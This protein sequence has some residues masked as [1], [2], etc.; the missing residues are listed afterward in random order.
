MARASSYSSRIPV[1]R[2]R[3]FLVA[4]RRAFRK[5]QFW[6]GFVILVPLLVWYT[7]FSFGPILRA[8]W[9][10]VVEYSLLEPAKSPFVGLK[11]FQL[12]FRQS[13]FWES[14]QHTL[15]Y[16]AL[17]FLFMLPLALAISVCLTSVVRGRSF[18]QFAIFLPVVVSLVSISLM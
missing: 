13:L 11:N 4:T 10:T 9:M 8:F 14:L 16:A 3:T 6:F 18:Y 1:T 12:L 17:F 15:T 2:S 5:P 7:V